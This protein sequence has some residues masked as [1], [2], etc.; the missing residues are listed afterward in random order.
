MSDNAPV[1]ANDLRARLRQSPAVEKESKSVE[2]LSAN[3]DEKQVD[4]ILSRH[5]RVERKYTAIGEGRAEA[6][7]EERAQSK[8]NDQEFKRTSVYMSYTEFAQ[9]QEQK[10]RCTKQRI[11]LT[12]TTMIRFALDQFSK[13][14]DAELREAANKYKQID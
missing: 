10:M 14:T 1:T 11:T 7:K 13:M 12:Y 2:A 9:F 5:K 4:E 3:V 6:F 8:R